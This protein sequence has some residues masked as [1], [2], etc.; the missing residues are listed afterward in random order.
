LIYAPD[1]QLISSQ[2]LSLN[3]KYTLQVSAPKGSTTFNLEIGLDTVQA[4]RALDNT[5]SQCPEQPK[6]TLSDPDVKPISLSDQTINVS[7]KASNDKAVGYVFEAKSGQKLSYR[8]HDDVCI[9]VYTPDNQLLNNGELPKTGN[10]ALQVSA[11]KGSTTFNLEMSLGTVQASLPLSSSTS[12]ETHS[13]PSPSTETLSSIST[14]TEVADLSQEQALE[15]I[16]NWY[17]AKSQIFGPPF[18][19]SLVDQYTVGK[20]YQ[21]TVKPGG[22]ID[23]LR[24]KDSYYTY[25]NSQIN[26][27]VLFSNSGSNPTIVVNVSEELYLHTSQGISQSNSG[28]YTANVIYFFQKDNEVWKIYDYQVLRS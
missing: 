13:S 4:Y 11:R 27:V 25:N 9:W 7:G 14:T 28:S 6:T 10:Y 3:G 16:E 24:S 2:K 8:T 5:S 18:D 19:Q 17:K 22:S 23:S 21:N 1:N 20:L 12:T 15:L 26:K